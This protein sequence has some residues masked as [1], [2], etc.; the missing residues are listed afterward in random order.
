M[1]IIKLVTHLRL[2]SDRTPADGFLPYPIKVLFYNMSII[3]IK[4]F[5]YSI[6]RE[7]L[8]IKLGCS[9]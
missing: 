6:I 7:P 3:K 9:F 1:F 2:A 5:F 4:K 8:K